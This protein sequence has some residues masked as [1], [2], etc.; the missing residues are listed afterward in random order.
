[1]TIPF[2]E[3]YP[4]FTSDGASDYQALEAPYCDF[5]QYPSYAPISEPNYGRKES[6]HRSSG[7]SP[8]HPEQV[9]SPIVEEH[10][11]YSSLMASLRSY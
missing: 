5:S 10:L 3:P 4:T 8:F 7:F 2:P 9:A 1:M 11:D 6:T